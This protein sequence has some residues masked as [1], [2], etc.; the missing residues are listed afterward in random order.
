MPDALPRPT[1]GRRRRDGSPSLAVRL[2]M[3]LADSG[4]PS[5]DRSPDGSLGLLPRR[6][7]L[8]PVQGN[9]DRISGAGGVTVAAAARIA[10]L[11]ASPLAHPWPQR[12]RHDGAMALC[13]S[14]APSREAIMRTIFLLL[15]GA[16][17]SCATGPSPA[18]QS[19]DARS[20]CQQLAQ[21]SASSAEQRSDA[22]F[23]QCM[24][25]HSQR[26]Q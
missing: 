26:P 25:A 13:W 10:D 8:G 23:D 6:G 1:H 24:I 7:I 15:S 5:A 22:Y 11:A 3:L 17:C 14:G 20:L 9:Q 12:G 2:P 4:A 18:P 19:H 16:L 21:V